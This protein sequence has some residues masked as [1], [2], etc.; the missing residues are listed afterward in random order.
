MSCM[1]SASPYKR[2]C[3]GTKR[4]N[5]EAEKPLHSSRRITNTSR[6]N[7]QASLIKTQ[8]TGTSVM[9][10][11]LRLRACTAGGTGLILG[12]GTKIPHAGPA[13]KQNRK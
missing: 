12:Q 1:N 11:W 6:V 5:V 2:G 8:K 7:F 13:R 3:F 9:L 4:S 10:Q